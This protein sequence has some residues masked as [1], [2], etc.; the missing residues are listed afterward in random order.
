LVKLKVTVPGEAE[1]VQM[2]A[3]VSRCVSLTTALEGER[4]PG[5]GL[6]FFC[7]SGEALA[8]WDRFILKA[9]K[10]YQDHPEADGYVMA[11]LLLSGVQPDPAPAS[12]AESCS[13]SKAT[14]NLIFRAHTLERLEDFVRHELPAG[15]IDIKIPYRV[16]TN[17]RVNLR[18]VHPGTREEFA[19]PGTAVAREDGEGVLV[20]FDE[21]VT[22]MIGLFKEFVRTGEPPAERR[23]WPCTA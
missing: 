10:L 22:Q 14:T 4:L 12:P 7:L 18:V 2:M 8:R 16:G 21:A 20:R 23:E 13:E 1:P 5:V 6:E 9:R 19:L 3:K 17:A 11:G 15:Q